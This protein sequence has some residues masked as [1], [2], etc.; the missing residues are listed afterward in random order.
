LRAASGS[1]LNGGGPLRH[2]AIRVSGSSPETMATLVVARDEDKRLR[3]AT[4]RAVSGDDRL[5]SFHVNLHSRDDA[6]IF[7][8]RTHRVAGA[9]RLRDTIAD[10]TFLISPTAFFQTNI[11]AA[12]VMVNLVQGAVPAHAPVLDLYAGSGLFALPLAR[13]GHRVIAVEE[14]A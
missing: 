12:E 14:S 3:T 8:P 10:T 1:T 9:A 13:C 7:G 2:L 6:F 4:R 11:H 5:T